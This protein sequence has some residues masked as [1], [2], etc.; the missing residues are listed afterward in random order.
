MVFRVLGYLDGGLV[1]HVQ[2]RWSSHGKTKFLQHLAHP[3]DLLACLSSGHVLGFSGGQSDN[4]LTLRHPGNDA[5]TYPDNVGTSGTTS[6]LA[7]C[8]VGV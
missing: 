7:T 8:M 6:V 4:R 2:Q 3:N 5:S 1:V